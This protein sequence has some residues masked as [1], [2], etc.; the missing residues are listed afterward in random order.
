VNPTDRLTMRVGS[1]LDVHPFGSDGDRPLRLAGVEV[2]GAPGLEGHSDADV[3]AHAVADALLGA[4]ALGDLGSRFGVGRPELAGADSLRLLAEV[5]ADVG[6]EGY[7]VGNVDLTIVAQ[8]PRLAAHR[9]QMRANLA[10]VLQVQVDRV[11]VKAT[12]TDRLGTVGRGEGIAAWA[13]C[14][15]VLR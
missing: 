15:V 2:L 5:L 10:G 8:R 6:A 1:G 9:D 4:C 12:T 3:A 13:T 11:S 14:T 7:E